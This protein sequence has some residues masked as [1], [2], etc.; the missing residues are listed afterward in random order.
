MNYALV[1]ILIIVSLLIIYIAYQFYIN[2][3]ILSDDWV[4]PLVD[5]TK[6]PIKIIPKLDNPTTSRYAIGGWIYINSWN[7][8][9]YKILLTKTAFIG[10]GNVFSQIDTN[11][12]FCL[13]FDESQPT[14]LFQLGT[15]QN[16]IPIKPVTIMKDFPLQKWTH[17]I[18]SVDMQIIDAYINGKL[19]VSHKLE[20]LP[21]NTDCGIMFG[22]IFTPIDIKIN[23]FERW[24]RS[25]DAETVW[26]SY[27]NTKTDI[28]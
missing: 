7:S 25:L 24:S 13:Y 3:T 4:Y 1:V 27:L 5:L 21:K 2:T 9:D 12:D 15:I 26:N 19:M 20:S 14:L 11:L 17:V 23:K 6:S 10:N 22:Y 8:D 28:K 18:I 16:S